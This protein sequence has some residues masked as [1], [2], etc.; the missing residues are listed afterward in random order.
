MIEKTYH[1]LFVYK[2]GRKEETPL[3]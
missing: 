3:N 2:K 1:G